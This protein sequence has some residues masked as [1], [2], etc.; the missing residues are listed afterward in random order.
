[1]AVDAAGNVVVSGYANT[2]TG[3]DWKTTKFNGATGAVLWESAFNGTGGGDDH[4]YA[5]T[6]DSTPCTCRLG[7]L[8]GSM[9]LAMRYGVLWKTVY[10]RMTESRWT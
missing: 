4:A 5:M 9:G 6:L 8:I 7:A 2:A 1:M 10:W 3:F